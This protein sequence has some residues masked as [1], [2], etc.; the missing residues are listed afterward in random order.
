MF[1]GV[2]GGYGVV[3]CVCCVHFLLRRLDNSALIYFKI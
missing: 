3:C 1:G 2:E